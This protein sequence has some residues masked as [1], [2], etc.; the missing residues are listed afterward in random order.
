IMHA[1]GA[2]DLVVPAG[3]TVKGDDV[4]VAGTEPKTQARIYRI[5]NANFKV[6][7]EG[8]GSLSQPGNGGSA[9]A[10]DNSGQPTIHEVKPR[11]YDRLYWILGM[12]FAI[13]GLGSVLLYRNT[14]RNS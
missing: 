11:I 3:V 14:A 7:V 10:E 12:C 2:S 13:L 4:E 9:A 8:T 5:K 1:E 6:E